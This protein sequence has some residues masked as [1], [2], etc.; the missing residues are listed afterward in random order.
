[1][2]VICKNTKHFSVLPNKAH[3]DGTRP[4]HPCSLFECEP[5]VPLGQGR[6]LPAG[7]HAGPPATRKPPGGSG[8]PAGGQLPGAGRVLP[9]WAQRAA[10]GHSVPLTAWG[11]R[12]WHPPPRGLT[13]AGTRPGPAGLPGP[14]EGTQGTGRGRSRERRA[15]AELAD[16]DSRHAAGECSHLHL[17]QDAAEQQ[18]AAADVL[19]GPA[20][21]LQPVQLLRVTLAHRPELLGSGHSAPLP[22]AP[23]LHPR[24]GPS[25][26][27]GP[28]SLPSGRLWGFHRRVT[29]SS[30][31]QESARDT[32]WCT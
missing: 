26:P 32:P 15:R 12:L 10:C 6:R 30:H 8:W 2:E 3:T 16:A 17:P 24:S 21:H 20:A 27:S 9:E 11:R 14:P 29:D 31:V 7:V 28:C 23:R 19:E 13:T 18:G 5:S 1:M 22:T 25:G 4:H